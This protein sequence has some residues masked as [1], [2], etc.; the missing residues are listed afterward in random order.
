MKRKKDILDKLID[1]E[2]TEEDKIKVKNKLLVS[3]I[4][5]ALIALVLLIKQ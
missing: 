5:E 3:Q 4:I 1:D 2:I